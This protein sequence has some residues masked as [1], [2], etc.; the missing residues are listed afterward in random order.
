MDINTNIFGR[1]EDTIRWFDNYLKN[2]TG[3]FSRSVDLFKK[4][5]FKCFQDLIKLEYDK[6]SK[7]IE[8]QFITDKD[9]DYSCNY[10]NKEDIDNCLNNN[11]HIQIIKIL[12]NNSYL[13]D[14]CLEWGLLSSKEINN[15]L[16]ISED[17]LKNISIVDIYNILHEDNKSKISDEE[18]EELVFPLLKIHRLNNLQIKYAHTARVVYL[19]D[20]QVNSLGIES[21]LVKDIVLTSALFHDV[22]RFYQGAFYNSFDD[23]AMKSM[24]GNGRGHAEAGYYYSLL[25]MISLNTLGVNTSDDLIIHAIAS[26]VVSNHQKSNQ[27]NNSFDEVKTNMNYSKDIDKKLYQF[28]YDAYLN[29]ESFP[30]GVHRRFGK[31]NPHQQK[32]MKSS[33]DNILRTIRIVME[34]YIDDSVRI[35]EIM[36]NTEEFLGGRI[37]EF[38]IERN[39]TIEGYYNL[40]E[41][42]ILESIIDKEELNKYRDNNGIKVNKE[43]SK[44]LFDYYAY[45][46]ASSI[47][48]LT[49]EEEK[50]IKDFN[51]DEEEEQRLIIR[52]KNKYTNEE[53]IIRTPEVNKILNEYKE[54]SFCKSQDLDFSHYTKIFSVAKN[55]LAKFAQFD[56]SKSIKDIFEGRGKTINK[57]DVDDDIRSIIDLSLN[58][59]MDADKIDILVQ[60]V[61]KRWDNWNPNYITV[62]SD[63]KKGESFLDVIENVFHIPVNY[64]SNGKVIIDDI[65]RKI[66]IDNRNTNTSFRNSLDSIIDINQSEFDSLELDKLDELLKKDYQSITKSSKVKVNSHGK[67]IYD[68]NLIL[69]LFQIIGKNTKIREEF[70]NSGI[71][72][73]TSLEGK[74]IPSRVISILKDN[75]ILLEEID[76]RIKVSYD[77]MRKVF[78]IDSERIK[79]ERDLVLPEDLRNKMFLED[80]DRERIGNSKFP[81]GR[82]A[83]NNPNFDWGNIFP[84]IWW[85]IDQ[86][87]MTNMRSRKSFKFLQ[88]TNLLDRLR[89][90]Y[91]SKECNP[92]FIYFIDEVLKYAEEFINTINNVYIDSSNNIYFSNDMNKDLKKVEMFDDSLM[93]KV[94][95]EASRRYREKINSEDI[96]SML[97]LEEE[98]DREKE[99]SI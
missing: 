88:D 92:D 80:K 1:E 49:K 85:H 44:C 37:G 17:K 74:E 96:I 6:D 5:Y 20:Y 4:Y 69:Y 3:S 58:I 67:M 50:I 94:R 33:L 35:D 71:I 53:L 73:D 18:I 64:D 12:R 30:E 55:D 76:N 48:F 41:V 22:G 43:L 7:R 26:L 59:V 98:N 42:S 40:E 82:R 54:Y 83:S 11:Y 77:V 86:F 91:K 51:L 8:Y 32:Y 89:N 38:F 78:P 9:K 95:D 75:N 31:I 46:K 52:K 2:S 45:K 99:M 57:D 29:A 90:T 70:N 14:T 61:N 72:I 68:H 56:I 47:F 60:R 63:T 16:N 27:D 66:I 93:V 24:E 15:I 97:D 81:L 21:S 23:G 62:R 39:I 10:I 36:K 65:L 19:A 34:Q 28:I 25:D 84:A 79:L 87:I 13:R